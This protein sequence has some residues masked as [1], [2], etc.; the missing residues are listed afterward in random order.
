MSVKNIKRKLT[1]EFIGTFA[2]VYAGTGAIIVDS[3]TGKLTHIG[4]A[5]LSG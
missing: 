4:I 3:L 5:F 2:L 1:A